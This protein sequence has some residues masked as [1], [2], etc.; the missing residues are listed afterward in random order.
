[1]NKLSVVIPSRNEPYLQKT[2]DSLLTSAMG[3]IEVIVVLDGYWPD[4]PIESNSK[5]TLIHFSEPRGMRAAINAGARLA[6]GKYLMKCDA[7]CTFAEGFDIELAKSCRHD[8]TVVPQRYDAND[9][10]EEVQKVCSF[11]YINLPSFKG[12]KWPEYEKRAGDKPL[13]ELM[14]FQ[15]SCWF[16]FLDR[17]W[18]YGGIDEVNYGMMGREAQEVSLKTWLSGGRLL[19]NRNT[20]YAHWS[21]PNSH[22]PGRAEAKEK[23]IAYCKELWLNNKWP[24]QV[25]TLA[26]LVERFAPVPG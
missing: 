9:N 4:P 12:K 5:V 22:Y 13:A 19:L 1:V 24:L 17:F 2:I 25:R 20:W 11:E 16:M 18:F 7:H 14:T 21:K 10:F 15:G 3:E 6:K 23:S 8:W 26:W